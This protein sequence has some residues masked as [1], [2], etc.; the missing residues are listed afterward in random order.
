VAAQGHSLPTLVLDAG[1]GIRSL[2]GLLGGSPYRGSLLLS[3]L[4]WDHVQGVPFFAGGDRDDS[5][6]DV[7]LPAQDGLKGRDLMAQFM[8]PPAFPITP[9]GLRGDWTFHAV[10]PSTF[11]TDGFEVTACEIAH[12]GGRTYAFRVENGGSSIAY[13][14]DHA[15]DAGITD[16][17]MAALTGV[18]V[19]IHD[20]Q[21]LDPERVIADAYGH[22]TVKDAIEFAQRLEVGTL[23]LFHHGPNRRDDALDHIMDGL[24]A[25]LPVVVATEGLILDVA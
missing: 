23:V 9:E 7:F 11:A 22:A 12:K 24:T 16:E 15:P 6:L 19:L 17:T 21:F 1:T 8:S 3:H 13:A 2:T 20:A 25:D 10:E 4:H 14:P 18:D 5:R